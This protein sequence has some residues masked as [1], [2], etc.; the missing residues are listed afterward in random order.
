LCHQ[1]KKECARFASSALLSDGVTILLKDSTLCVESTPTIT[2][3]LDLAAFGCRIVPLDAG[4]KKPHIKGWKTQAT[5]DPET[6]QR[7]WQRWPDANVGHVIPRKRLVID[8]D[9][10]HGG[11]TRWESLLAQH[12]ALPPTWTVWTGRQD[13]G[14]H[15][16][17][18]VPASID[19]PY[20]TTLAPG[21]EVLG[22]QHEVL[23]P[24]S[25]H[26][27][28]GKPYVWDDTLSPCEGCPEAP[29]PDWLI[30]EVLKH[31][32]PRKPQAK[33]KTQ[34]GGS[35]ESNKEP[36]EG[37]LGSLFDSSTPSS[38]PPAPGAALVAK[39]CDPAHLPGMLEAC[40]LDP[41]L[42][43]GQSLACPMHDDAHPSAVL[44]GP[45]EAH[46]S[47]G[48]VCH[49]TACH[50][51]PG[52]PQPRYYSLVD[53]YHARTS[54]NVLQL[55]T[56]ITAQGR[57]LDHTALRLQWTARLLEAAGAL[58]VRELGAPTLPPTAPDDARDLWNIFLHVRRLRS[59]TRDAD[60]PLPFSLR[61]I[62][63]WSGTFLQWTAYRV[64]AAK[65]WLLAHG[66]LEWAY[67]DTLESFWR[68]GRHAL[69]RARRD[70][71]ILRTEHAIVEDVAATE[72][73][74]PVQ[75]TSVCD[76]ATMQDHDP[77]RCEGCVSQERL[78]AVRRR[79]GIVIDY[80]NPYG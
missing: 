68:V 71:P 75:P 47:F 24:P 54:G 62:L 76:L 29:A 36:Q 11:L 40:G 67:K 65:K 25:I 39:A 44:L 35:L 59:L 43:V 9:P 50:V 74:E 42:Q 55:H 70:A 16:Y 19:I 6:L 46:P 64:S 30:A 78:L 38:S 72:V 80:A 18:T 8:I 12:G 73:P 10:R 58:H 69:R 33:G 77:L 2:D 57:V 60:A 20:V 27:A 45:T 66:Y 48:I 3:V 15:L 5:T 63:D 79:N 4:T 31:A 34:K 1:T 21:V 13:G 17:F 7:W 52:K 32:L 56:E 41:T 53:L 26:P 23:L 37:G 61:F 14:F 22:F 28:T 51:A 49:A